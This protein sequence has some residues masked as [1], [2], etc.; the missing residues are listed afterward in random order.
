MTKR[1]WTIIATI[2]FILITSYG[3]MK[4]LI[5]QKPDIPQRPPRISERWV[6]AVPVAYNTIQSPVQAKGRVVSS[7]EVDLVSEAAGRIESGDVPLKKGQSFK[8]GQILFTIYKD[9]A[10]LALKAQ[11][12]RFLN[13]V[14]NLLPDIHIDYPENEAAFKSFFDTIEIDQPL[15]PLPKFKDET[16][17]IFLS[18]RNL[19]ADYYAI[20]QDELQL[21]R[22]SVK[23]PFDGVFTTISLEVGAYTN[24][25][26]R[27]GSMIA[28]DELE[29]DVAVDNNNAHWMKPGDPVLLTSGERDQTW[30]GTVNRVSQFVDESTQSRSVFVRVPLNSQASLYA[31]E[32]LNAEFQGAYVE[33]VIQ[34]PR[35]AIFNYNEVFTIEDR[36]LKIT[37][38][39]VVK[40]NETTALIRGIEDG[41]YLVTQPL[42][43]VSE[44]TAVKILGIDQVESPKK[45]R[46]MDS[47]EKE[48]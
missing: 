17:K 13:T 48:S 36:L 43:N 12:S 11:K 26:G 4:F 20:L 41:R 14:A 21:S 15:P 5:A 24:T 23:A 30:Q 3:L 46:K 44:N 8:K 10:E 34:I 32:Y 16:F 2:I 6:K 22:H 33:N 28:T 25:G 45:S 39:E 27:V 19:L 35:N 7:A 37:E 38:V 40:L 18:S 31:G 42:I 47:E 29:V 9:E 1:K